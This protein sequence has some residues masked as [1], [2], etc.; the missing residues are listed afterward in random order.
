MGLKKESLKYARLGVECRPNDSGVWVALMDAELAAGDIERAKA[1]AQQ[2]A[3]VNPAVRESLPLVLDRIQKR[4]GL[5][6]S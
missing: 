3:E 1:A 4:Q 5:Q 6:S 2:A